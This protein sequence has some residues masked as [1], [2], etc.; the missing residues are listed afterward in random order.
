MVEQYIDV[1]DVITA[2]YSVVWCRVLSH[3]RRLD[4]VI[5][6]DRW[7]TNSAVIC[8][9]CNLQPADLIHVSYRN[10]VCI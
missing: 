7:L 2:Q 5:I 4:G 9:V 3:N 10:N 1:M 6:D 8:D